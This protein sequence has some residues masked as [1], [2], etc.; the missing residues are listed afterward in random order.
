MR[1]QRMPVSN[2]KETLVLVLQLN[3]IFQ[4]AVIVAQV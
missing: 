1:S 3:P 2:K 4:D